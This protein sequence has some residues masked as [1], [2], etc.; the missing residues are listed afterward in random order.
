[1]I[2]PEWLVPVILTATRRNATYITAEGA[3]RR[4]AERTE[5]PVSF[6]PPALGDAVRVDA[7]RHGAWPVFTITPTAS[8]PSGGIVFLH[9]G[10]WVNEIAPQHWRL[11]AQIAVESNTTVTVP[12]YPLV[13]FGTAV[14]AA[15]TVA[16]I[17]RS[18]IDQ[19]G[20]VCLIGDSA[21]GQIALSVAMLL[22]DEGIV[23]PETVL[24][25]PALDL[26][27]SNPRIPEVQPSDPWLGVPGGRVLADLWA[28][29]ADIR[30]PLV[31]PLFGDLTGLGPITVFTGTRDVLNPDVRL[32][33]EK[34]TAAGVELTVV[35][36][37]GRVHVYPLLP[38]R[39]GRD[40]RAAIV[41]TIARG[42]STPTHV[43]DEDGSSPCPAG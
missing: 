6:D 9:G 25:S 5:H 41:E 21:G 38:T 10:A 23:L 27:W 8:T 39:S 37:A 3:R 36:A 33:A 26:T 29:G 28:G 1:M 4:V 35:E 2:V 16:A 22:R 18:G 31:S 19:H 13:P 7:G 40:A 14:P 12:I 11:A 24:I 17:V 42:T 20:Q 32:L 43:D 34:A 15:H 30:D